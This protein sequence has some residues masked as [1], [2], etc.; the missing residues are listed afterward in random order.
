M[1]F[2]PE[3]SEQDSSSAARS[4]SHSFGFYYQEH[5]LAPRG[6]SPACSLSAKPGCENSSVRTK[7]AEHLA[8]VHQL[9]LAFLLLKHEIAALLSLPW[10]MG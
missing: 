2:A 8:I 1:S 9:V 3:V 4:R 6:L 7:S 5:L 10:C